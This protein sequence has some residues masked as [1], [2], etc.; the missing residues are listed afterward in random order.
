[1]SDLISSDGPFTPAQLEVLRTIVNQ[2]IPASTEYN[3]PSA[4]DETI[5]NDIV[6]SLGADEDSRRQV[7]RLLDRIHEHSPDYVSLSSRAQADITNEIRREH[8]EPAST[9][10]A[11]T[12]L[13][14]YRDDRVMQSLD[15]EARAPFPEGYEV[16][17]GD[18]SLLDPV[19]RRGEIYRKI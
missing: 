19:R 6:S 4:A 12:A 9:L 7:Q 17:Q 11:A 1:M 5:F 10:T 2:I 16:D 18:W 8:A 15:M 13:C 14:Y 3:V